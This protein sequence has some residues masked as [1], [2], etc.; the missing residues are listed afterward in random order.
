[1]FFFS[2]IE[3]K[4]KKEKKRLPGHGSVLNAAPCAVLQRDSILDHVR[5]KSHVA[6]EQEAVQVKDSSSI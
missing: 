3:K 6:A 4:K 1:M 5:T 2:E